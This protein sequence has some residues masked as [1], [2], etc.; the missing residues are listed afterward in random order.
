MLARRATAAHRRAMLTEASRLVMTMRVRPN[1]LPVS[2]GAAGGRQ[3]HQLVRPKPLELQDHSG[4]NS[5]PDRKRVTSSNEAMKCSFSPSKKRGPWP[6]TIGLTAMW[7]SLTRPHCTR[8]R[9]SVGLATNRI[10]PSTW[11]RS[12]A[13]AS[14]VGAIRRACQSGAGSRLRQRTWASG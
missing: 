5:T 10:V 9:A 13:I 1:C 3:L 14:A 7:Y 8:V 2:W 6:A 12:V 11:S 4:E